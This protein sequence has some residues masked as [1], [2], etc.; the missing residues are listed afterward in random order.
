MP[1][2]PALAES[3]P[4]STS[5][6][7]C[8]SPTIFSR[9]RSRYSACSLARVRLPLRV[10]RYRRFAPRWLRSRPSCRH[11]R[12]QYRRHRHPSHTHT[13][14]SQYPQRSGMPLGS[15]ARITAPPR[16]D[17]LPALPRCGSLR[18]PVSSTLSGAALGTPESDQLFDRRSRFFARRRSSTPPRRSPPNWRPDAS[19]RTSSGRNS[20]DLLH[21]S[22]DRYIAAESTRPLA[23]DFPRILTAVDR[24]PLCATYARLRATWHRGALETSPTPVEKLRRSFSP[25]PEFMKHHRPCGLACFMLRSRAHGPD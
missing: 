14:H 15:L 1:I 9:R 6:G 24:R 5:R 17:P 21:V 3:S 2:A 16:R 23:A 11:S 19:R 22:F 20:C 25:A 13:T 18:A 4:P 8:C 12:P 7:R 10:C